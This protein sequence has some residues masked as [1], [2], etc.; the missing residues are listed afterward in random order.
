MFA[1]RHY[2]SDSFSKHR[3]G[4]ATSKPKRSFRDHAIAAKKTTEKTKKVDS[5][6]VGR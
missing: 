3:A 5:P 6:P 4:K 2:Q 1:R